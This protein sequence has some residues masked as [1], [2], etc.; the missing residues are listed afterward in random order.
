LKIGQLRVE[1]W[2]YRNSK[3]EPFARLVFEGE[4]PAS[5]VAVIGGAPKEP[6][7]DSRLDPMH[8][9]AIAVALDR[10]YQSVIAE[11]GNGCE[12]YFS[13]EARNLSVRLTGSGAIGKAPAAELT[14][15][16]Y[17]GLIEK[18]LMLTPLE[19]IVL[20]GA[21]YSIVAGEEE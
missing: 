17:D 9:S 11:D 3:K 8:A 7:F 14:V 12:G 10:W 4:T 16:Q 2:A 5:H 1:T 6:T 18:T 13:A 15:T 19:A 20:S 21:L